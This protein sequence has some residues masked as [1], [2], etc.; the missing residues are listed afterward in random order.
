MNIS[1]YLKY[2]VFA[3]AAVFFGCASNLTISDENNGST[4]T[5]ETGKVIEVKLGGQM[6]T[7]YSWKW[8]SNDFFI[9]EGVP[10]I[11]PVDKRPGGRELTVFTLRAAK[12]GETRLIFRY[13]R[14]WE[15]KQQPE[16][17]YSVNAVITEGKK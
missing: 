5:V 9:Q 6:G 2:A 4:I 14:E 16:K 3:M 13:Q 10:K 17:E 12:L 7:G 15:K 11:T 1:F 8:I